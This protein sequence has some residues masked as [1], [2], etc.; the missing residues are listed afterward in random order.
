MMG[1][2]YDLSG[3][4]REALVEYE[5]WARRAGD[6]L[7][8]E[9]SNQGHRLDLAQARWSMAEMHLALG[10]GAV[11]LA[12]ARRVEADIL[13]SDGDT[14][15]A[16]AAR[17]ALGKARVIAARALVALGAQEDAFALAKAG[18]RSLA[19]NEARTPEDAFAARD[20]DRAR[21]QAGIVGLDSARDRVES[22]ALVAE[23]RDQLRAL[24]ARKRLT[25][26]FRP[27]LETA[28]AGMKRCAQSG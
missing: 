23:G 7:R 24:D 15:E 2:A 28:D 27:V 22:C 3:R 17:E 21:I 6:A 12:E 20:A 13:A 9:P 14:P 25:V 19:I 26:Q 8:K 11:A 10:Q 18:L 5:S 16:E 4:P 1:Y